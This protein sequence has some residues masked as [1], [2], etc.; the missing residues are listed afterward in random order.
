MPGATSSRPVPARTTRTGAGAAGEEA[1]GR[2]LPSGAT[3]PSG[4]ADPDE[5]AGKPE[6]ADGVADGV[7]GAGDPDAAADGDA[8]AGAAIGAAGAHAVRPRAS[9][10]PGTRGT[11]RAGTAPSPAPDVPGPGALVAPAG[12]AEEEIDTEPG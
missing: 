2:A 4:A 7:D 11:R 3:E 6:P 10:R 8:G 1:R 9:S 5:G 12:T